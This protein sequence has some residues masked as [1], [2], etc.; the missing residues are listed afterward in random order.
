[1]GLTNA[2]ILVADDD[3]DTVDT[4]ADLLRLAGYHVQVVYDGLQALDATRLFHPHVVILDINMPGMDGFEV[5]RAIRKEFGEHVLLVAH[6]ALT[7][8]TAHEQARQA[9]FDEQLLKPVDSGRLLAVVADA[10]GSLTAVED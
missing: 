2:R 7:G 10:V 4:T 6:T 9:G 8:M 3:R 1:M 5:A